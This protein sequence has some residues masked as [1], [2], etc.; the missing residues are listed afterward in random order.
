MK[1]FTYLRDQLQPDWMPRD[2]RLLIVAR[3]A[4]SAARA[5]AGVIVP[6][7]LA[8]TGF[9]AGQLGELFGVVALTSAI[10]STAVGLLADRVGRKLFVVLL[11]LFTM[12]A[13][14]VFALSHLDALLV[15]FAALGSFGRG[16]G[17]GAGSIGPYQ[18]AEQAL[19]AD[20]TPSRHRNSVFGRLA[21][22]SS[23]GAVVGGPLA[24]IPQLATSFGLRGIA[25]YRP[26]FFAT[27]I[28]AL[29]A[30]LIVLPIAN[31]RAARRPGRNPFQFPRH[32]WPLLFKLWA[33]NS[34]NGLAVGFFGPFI[35]YWF[36]RRYG[37]TPGSIGLLF[38]VINLATMVSTLGAANVA[39]QLGL[40]RAI[41]VSRVIS[42]MLLVVMV[43][44]PAF[45]LAGAIYLIRMLAQRVSLPLRQ[46]YVMGMAAP[47]ERA[48]VAALSSIPAQVT[49]AA[50]PVAAGYLFEEV[51]LALPFEIGAILQTINGIMYYLF[52]HD[53]HPPEESGRG[54]VPETRE[55]QPAEIERGTA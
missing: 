11:P 29:V 26:A 34:V 37:A 52:F 8:Q 28:L 44:A 13:S 25:A 18:P 45:W 46:S 38:T 14:I 19:V 5:L 39:R 22:A 47:A 50:T 53:L 40:V 30:A 36:Y 16:A 49:S 23:V 21:F 35:T 24:A 7:Y 17:A 2:V 4:M 33:T 32:S 43:Q 31:P 3:V 54:G 6:I 9:S 15:V 27:A 42:A 20:A 12:A 51:S 55:P 1:F 41:V 48:S 10:L